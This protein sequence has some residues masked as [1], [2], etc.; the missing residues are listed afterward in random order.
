LLS[1]CCNTIKKRKKKGDGKF[2]TAI[3]QIACFDSK[4]KKQSK[5]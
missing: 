1:W 3:A 2:G 5:C 4:I